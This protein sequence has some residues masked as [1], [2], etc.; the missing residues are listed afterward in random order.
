MDGRDAQ[1]LIGGTRYES[2]PMTEAQQAKARAQK[3]ELMVERL[4]VDTGM[5]PAEVR[6]F[7]V[8]ALQTDVH[9]LQVTGHLIP[10]S[11]MPWKV[12]FG[13]WVDDRIGNLVVAGFEAF[14]GWKYRKDGRR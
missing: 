9:R 13:L 1:V 3:L 6:R 2:Y 8:S 11:E 7:L 4:A 10:R 5:S 14:M 12:R